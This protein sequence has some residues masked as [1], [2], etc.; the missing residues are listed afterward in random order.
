MRSALILLV[1]AGILNSCSSKSIYEQTYQLDERINRDLRGLLHQWASESPPISEEDFS[2]QSDT[3]QAVYQVFEAFYNLRLGNDYHFAAVQPKLN[4]I[5][6]DSLQKRN[7]LSSFIAMGFD[8]LEE[9]RPRLDNTMAL[10]LY[11][12]IENPLLQFLVSDWCHSGERGRKLNFLQKN[13]VYIDAEIDGYGH[14]VVLLALNAEYSQ[15]ILHANVFSY[16]MKKKNNEWAI[17]DNWQTSSSG[18][19]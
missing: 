8:T 7:P 4:Y 18:C 17:V 15:A 14:D 13:S 6:V 1:C 5:I 9:F 19:E 11:D 3:V 16:E 10:Y 2:N 12:E